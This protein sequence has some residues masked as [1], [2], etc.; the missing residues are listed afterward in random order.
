MMASMDDLWRSAIRRRKSHS[1]Y[2]PLPLSRDLGAQSN[3]T[4]V[5]AYCPRRGHVGRS[6]FCEGKRPASI[7]HA[8]R[9]QLTQ[10]IRNRAH[11][12]LATMTIVRTHCRYKSKENKAPIRLPFAPIALLASIAAPFSEAVMA[13]GSITYGQGACPAT[14]HG[15][16]AAICGGQCAHGLI[17]DTHHR[18]YP[19]PRG[20]R[21]LTDLAPPLLGDT[22]HKQLD[23][24]HKGRSGGSGE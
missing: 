6:Q 9:F 7:A 21:G 17:M 3:I 20:A 18:S 24:A 13:R 10:S 1:L 16:V 4:I 23:L 22:D 19:T 8:R 11:G 15:G 14:G 2:V 12:S 5:A